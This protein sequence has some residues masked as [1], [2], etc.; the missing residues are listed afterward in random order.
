MYDVIIIGARVAGSPTGML[1]ARK[2]YQVLV[3]DRATF[4]SNTLS[5][6][7]IQ[8]YGSVRLKRWGLLERVQATNCP[9]AHRVKFDLGPF[10]LR[11]EYPSLEGIDAVYSPRRIVLDKILVDAAREAGAEVREGFIVE[12][13]QMQDGRITGIRGRAKNGAS[14]TEQARIVIGADGLHSIVART[15]Q[16]ST[17]HA[18]PAMSCG[19]YTYYCDVLLEGGEIYSRDR[20]A[21]G[22]WPTNDGL[23]MVFTAWPIT[24]FHQY[25]ADIEGSFLKTIDLAPSLAERLRQGKRAERFMG[26][27]DLPNF[28]RKPYGPGWALVG[29]AGYHKDPVTGLGISD[30]FRDAE[31]LAEAIDAGFSGR[32]PL[33]EALTDY[34]AQRNRASMPMYEF[35]T[36]LASFAPPMIEQQVLFEALRRNQ[37]A[38][39]QFFGA[40]TGVVPMEWFFSSQNL[41]RILGIGGLAKIASQKLWK[42]LRPVKQPEAMLISIH[43]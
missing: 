38:T 27:A 8:I 9:P 7:Q 1:L 12:D 16:A 5:T 19:Y 14:S 24:E 2:G 20:R 6:H 35:T 41:F 21:I 36:Q 4:P 11:G 18:R 3:V 28:Y 13:I 25:R 17:Y 39:D 10:V 23:T 22:A 37:A 31:F 43:K 34:E 40:M 26:T 30:A 33:D 42:A 29:D 15:V 32:K